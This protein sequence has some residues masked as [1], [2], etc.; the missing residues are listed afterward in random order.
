MCRRY[1]DLIRTNTPIFQLYGECQTR[2]IVW[3]DEP[4]NLI[5]IWMRGC[6]L[7][8]RRHPQ[9]IRIPMN[10]LSTKKKEKKSCQISR[11][12]RTRT[13]MPSVRIRAK[14]FIPLLLKI[15]KESIPILV[16][17]V[18]VKCN[19]RI[20]W[21][22]YKVWTFASGHSSYT[23]TVPMKLKIRFVVCS[24]ISDTYTL[25]PYRL[26]VL[27]NSLPSTFRF[28]V[29]LSSIHALVW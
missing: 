2:C 28:E 26:C 4:F 29:K 19:I 21:W 13:T 3:T 14:I 15:M 16:G 18:C 1:G 6:C 9:I 25:I 23:M 27:M 7:C 17:G 24:L 11:A 10:I 20:L 12:S 8:A 22:E 5:W